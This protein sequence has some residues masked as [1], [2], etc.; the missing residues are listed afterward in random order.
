MHRPHFQCDADRTRMRAIET[1]I[2]AIK[3]A[4]A[5]INA[6]FAQKKVATNALSANEL[7]VAAVLATFGK[8]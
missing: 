8:K 5:E 2:A 1:N 7:E 4:I 3:T 6:D